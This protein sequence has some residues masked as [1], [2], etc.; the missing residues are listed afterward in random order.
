MTH[1]SRSVELCTEGMATADA[2]LAAMSSSPGR[3]RVSRET[4][5]LAAT[6]AV[7]VVVLLVLAQFR[8]PATSA[9]GR[10]VAVAQPLARLA[11]RAAFDDLSLAVRELSTRVDGSL[12]VVRVTPR[13]SDADGSRPSSGPRLVPALRVRDDAAV[14]ALPEGA[15]IDGIV[16]MPGPAATLARDPV[17]GL[18]LVRVPQSSAPVLG[19]R[20]GTQPLIAPG[21]VVVAEASPAGTSLRPVFIGRSDSV[22]DLRWD[23]PLLT[24]GRGVAGDVGAPVFLLDGRLA[25]LVTTTDGEPSLIPAQLVLAVVDGLLRSGAQPQGD[26]GVATQAVDAA[27]AAAT[28]VRSGAAIAAVAAEGPSARVLVPGDVVTAVGGQPVRTPEGLWQR[29]LRSAPGST[30][31][32][33][34]RRNG[35]F[36]T[37][38]V[39]VRA[40]QEGGAAPT[41][42][43]AS[44]ASADLPL[45]LTLRAVAGTGSEVVRVQDGSAGASAGVHVGD[46][47]VSLGASRA[48]SPGD[49]TEAFGDVAR[50][51][52]LFLSVLRDGE[53][54]LVAL[55]R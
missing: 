13:S 20:E 7:S 14:V 50:G 19:V 37:V 6:I 5:L 3:P 51:G 39:V 9:V 47:I 17:R 42:G 40:R 10:D 41:A 49:V 32:L 11:A 16:G 8:F 18:S 43:G 15:T 1:R 2:I 29:V 53:P 34:V 27:L 33:T 46:V 28:G 31:S 48:P 36:A 54:R 12:L 35:E 25:G 30:L 55:R 21:Y 52:S 24:I 45:G 38:P 44:A 26:I 22:S 23:S 4:R